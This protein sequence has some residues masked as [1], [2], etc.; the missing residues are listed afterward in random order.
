MPEYPESEVAQS[1]ERFA[2]FALLTVVALSFWSVLALGHQP[3]AQSSQ[4]PDQS[5]QQAEKPPQVDTESNPA[6]RELENK[7]M[8]ALK[9]DP[10]MA[11]SRVRVHVTET[12]VLLTGVVLTATAKDQAAQI[13]TDHAGGKKV[14]NHIK[15]NPNIHPAPG[16]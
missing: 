11:Y 3:L 4:A 8:D 12:E 5:Q 7:I 13:A 1:M 15:V 2:K 6:A 16:V 9:Q 14:V 10:H